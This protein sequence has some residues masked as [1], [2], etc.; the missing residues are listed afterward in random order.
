MC[1]IS[2]RFH[3]DMKAV[4]EECLS[5]APAKSSI[6]AVHPPVRNDELSGESWPQT[7]LGLGQEQTRIHG[8]GL[9]KVTNGPYGFDSSSQLMMPA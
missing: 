1:F 7:A 9:A 6:R 5:M 8:I 3:R 4:V 2:T